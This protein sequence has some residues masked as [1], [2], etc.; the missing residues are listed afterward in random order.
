MLNI[1]LWMNSLM[2]LIHPLAMFWLLF[3]C[4]LF[5]SLCWITQTNHFQTMKTIFRLWVFWESFTSAIHYSSFMVED[6]LL[7]PH[8]GFPLIPNWVFINSKIKTDKLWMLFFD[9]EDPCL[10]AYVGIHPMSSLGRKRAHPY[11]HTEIWALG[12]GLWT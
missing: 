10:P 4:S 9:C 12:K 6:W 1:E 2:S 7:K 11:K 3:A 8:S 5:I